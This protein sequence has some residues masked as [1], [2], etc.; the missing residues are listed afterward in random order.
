MRFREVISAP[1]WL[2]AIIY[3]F[4]LSIVISVWAALGNTAALATLAAVT[5]LLF[6]F[7]IKS[8]LVIEVDSTELRVGRAHIEHRYIGEV[9]DL[10]NEA[11]RLVR[12]RNADPNSHLEI[13]FWAN[14]GVQIFIDDE[15]DT[16]PYWLISTRKGNDLLKALKS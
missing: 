3:F 11:I 13:R 14:K 15:R 5:A 8:A 16:T 6:L 10:D 9:R 2:L 12:T 1:L 7:Y 4:L